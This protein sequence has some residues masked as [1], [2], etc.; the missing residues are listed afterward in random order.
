MNHLYAPKRLLAGLMAF[1]FA[2]VIAQAAAA[3]LPRGE[4]RYHDG[5]WIK[6]ERY[7]PLTKPSVE[8][9]Y[10][11]GFW[12]KVTSQGGKKVIVRPMSR[13]DDRAGLRGI[14]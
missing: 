10:H 11:N 4:Y 12:V 7:R 6:G 9:R 3:A 1:V 13:P 8:Y 5:E 14:G 2:L